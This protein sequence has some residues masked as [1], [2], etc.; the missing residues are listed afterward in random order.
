MC[1]ERPPEPPDLATASRG[2]SGRAP[3]PADSVNATRVPAETAIQYSDRLRD[4]ALPARCRRHPPELGT[5]RCVVKDD[6]AALI[7]RTLPRRVVPGGAPL[8]AFASHA[9]TPRL[10]GVGDAG[11][12]SPVASRAPDHRAALTGDQA[13]GGS[14]GGARAGEARGRRRPGGLGVPVRLAD[15]WA[16]DPKHGPQPREAALR[17]AVVDAITGWEPGGAARGRA[18]YLHVTG[19]QLKKAAGRSAKCSVGPGRRR[20]RRKPRR[21]NAEG[22]DRFRGPALRAGGGYEIRT[23]EGLPPTRFPSVRPRPLGESSA[24]NNTRRGGVLANVIV[25][26]GSGG[27]RGGGRGRFRGCGSARVGPSPS[28][29]AISPNSPRAGRQQG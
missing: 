1:T 28:R 20:R 6:R 14:P 8:V 29:G 7:G 17:D 3:V 19:L 21:G 5:P 26:R 13:A 23:R 2:R 11:R 18:Q 9:G 10:D 27:G 16:L 15:R 22:P 12:S 24:A 4:S 25:R